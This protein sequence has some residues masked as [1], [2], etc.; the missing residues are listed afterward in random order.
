MAPRRLIR[1]KSFWLGI[2]VLGFLAFGWVRSHYVIDIALMPGRKNATLRYFGS[3]NGAVH[4]G[5]E[6]SNYAIVG[7]EYHRMP[8]PSVWKSR[9][10]DIGEIGFLL[11]PFAPFPRPLVELSRLALEKAAH[12]NKRP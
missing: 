6:L 4:V 9:D 3:W 12:S 10:P 7:L 8:A 11:A 5:N 2:L 1:W